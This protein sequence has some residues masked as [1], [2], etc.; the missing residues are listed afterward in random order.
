[1]EARE[2]WLPEVVVST[3]NSIKSIHPARQFSYE[4]AREE[5]VLPGLVPDV[6]IKAGDRELHVEIRVAHACGP[7]KL[8]RLKKQR[9]SSFEID[10]SRVPRVGSREEHKCAV[11]FSARRYWLN[12]LKANAAEERLRDEAKRKSAADKAKRRRQHEFIAGGIAALWEQPAVAGEEYWIRNVQDAGYEPHVGIPVA[13]DRCF[14]VPSATWQSAF[15]KHVVFDLA[16]RPV[17]ADFTL[18]RLQEFGLLKAPFARRRN[19]NEELVTCV[20]E[21]V[22]DFCSPR[23]ALR[24]YASILVE[25]KVLEQADGE[26]WSAPA[27]ADR[28]AE[29]LIASA[30]QRRERAKELGERL[31]PLQR[32]LGAD[33]DT[34]VNA[35]MIATLPYFGRSPAEL[36]AAGGWPWTNFLERVASLKQMLVTGGSVLPED[37]WLGLP[38][39]A[40]CEARRQEEE[41][42]RV[43]M[44]A[45][46]KERRRAYEAKRWAELERKA[47]QC[48]GAEA[49][50]AFIRK[51]RDAYASDE[52]EGGHSELAAATMQSIEAD[53]SREYRRLA[54]L[55]ENERQRRQ[56]EQLR[57]QEEDSCRAELKESASRHFLEPGRAALWLRAKQPAIGM[58]P[59]E[60][61]TDKASLAQCRNLLPNKLGVRR[62]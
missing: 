26:A 29:S 32:A 39:A 30:V 56:M 17:G 45:R 35:W 58:S 7:E 3:G 18:K 14:L 50:A 57:A 5:V 6:I 47:E 33:S 34:I 31:A 48:L 43:E 36:V 11:L 44:E 27:G 1:M 16:G 21:R 61:C 40:H 52:R 20:R 46:E 4:S 13:G 54:T 51:A 53:L 15:I 42:R 38:L 19:W 60:Y 12:N 22:P 23:D 62:R 10:L 25:R 49:G 9:L 59:L 28:V 8:A 55:Q 24:K 37:G 2:I 41:V